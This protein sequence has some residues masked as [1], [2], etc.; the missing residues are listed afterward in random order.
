MRIDL[1]FRR[2]LN[3]FILL[4]LGISADLVYLQATPEAQAL[5]ASIYNPRHCV[6]DE[7]PQ[8]GTIY[9]RNGV[10]LAYSTPDPN[11]PC[12]WRRV[13]TDP[14]L[15]PILGFYDPQGFGVTGL[16]AA[17]DDV[18]SGYGTQQ[19]VAPGIRNGINHILDQA[20]HA[21][22]Y[23]SDV[24]L[25][26]DE[27]VQQKA[28]A[29]YSQNFYQGRPEDPEQPGSILVEDPHTGEMLA[30]ISH[31]SFDP[32]KVIDHTDAGD[33]SGLTVGQEYW[34]TLLQDVHRPLV[35]HAVMDVLPPGSAFK[36]MTLL[37]ALDSGFTPQFAFSQA[38]STNYV[39]DGF[40][41]NSNNLGDYRSIPSSK[42]FPMDLIHQYAFS[43]NV[44][45]ARLAVLEG[46]S[47]Y[48]NHAYSLGISYGNHVTNIPF[49]VPV[50][51]SWVYQP[52]YQSEWDRDNVALA[53]TGFGQGRLL[54]S[55][56]EQTVM[57]SAVA[58]DG[59][60]YKPHMLLKVVPHGVDQKT[61]P[62]AAP[63]LIAHVMSPTAAQG[64]REAMRAVVEYGSIGA[65]GATWAPVV[66]SPAL[67]GGKTGTAQTGQQTPDPTLLPIDTTKPHATFLSLAPDD[68][69][70]PTGNP[71]RLV[72]VINKEY[73]GEAA[74]QANIAQQLFEFTLPL[75]DPQYPNG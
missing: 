9:D 43:N 60:Y 34:N 46:K 15:A 6:V 59:A 65:S 64:V 54:I 39:V 70:N 72:I 22:T 63:Q 62:A 55:P 38:D 58:A 24:Y 69:S 10:V 50:A 16:E 36:T 37:S 26:I 13:Y 48:L 2:V 30:F 8:R 32:N 42:V 31:P 12:G 75:I 4:F 57:T 74:F 25:T 53:V 23:G 33:G 40:D 45:Y 44:A 28:D 20:E 19:L 18:L 47:V 41:I 29:L 7:T 1:P 61:V 67:I 52:Q 11:A 66:N 14:S 5:T 3:I 51:H 27:R 17:Y 49:D 56:L 68:T 71:P 35:D 21:K 73:E